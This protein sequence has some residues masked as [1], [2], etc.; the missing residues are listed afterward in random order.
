MHHRNLLSYVSA[1]FVRNGLCQ[2]G[3]YSHFVRSWSVTHVPLSATLTSWKS[4]PNTFHFLNPWWI[5]SIVLTEVHPILSLLK[6]TNSYVGAILMR[7]ASKQGNGTYFIQ[8]MGN[9][10]LILHD[11][12]PKSCCVI[13][14]FHNFWVRKQVVILGRFFMEKSPFVVWLS[15]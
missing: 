4:V 8:F 14:H 13:K 2:T 5:L 12:L 11:C 7:Q 15:R 1:A 6:L 3:Y 9:A 10:E